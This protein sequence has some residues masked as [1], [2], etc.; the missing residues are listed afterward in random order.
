DW[1]LAGER[2]ISTLCHGHA[3]LLA[4][5]IGREVSP[6]AGYGLCAFPDAADA[7]P[8][9]DIG[10]LPGAMPWSLCSA[11]RDQG[12]VLTNADDLTGAAYHDR[13]LLSGDSPLAANELGKMAASALVEVVS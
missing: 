1:V 9:V 11:L 5:S 8:N 2:L 12:L 7:D 10:C 4:A 3:A 13:N 6:F